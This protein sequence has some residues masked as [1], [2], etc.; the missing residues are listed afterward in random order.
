VIDR[1]KKASAVEKKRGEDLRAQVAVV[2]HILEVALIRAFT[3]GFKKIAEL[4]ALPKTNQL[5]KTDSDSFRWEIVNAR[6][7]VQP[8]KKS[9]VWAVQNS[10]CNRENNNAARL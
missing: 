6:F 4:R 2:S 7:A 3:R 5:E 10:S 1:L 8:Q 9:L